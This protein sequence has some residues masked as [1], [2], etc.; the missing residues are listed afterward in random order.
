MTITAR[1]IHSR[2]SNHF[3]IQPPLSP[4]TTN[5]CPS[6]LYGEDSHWPVIG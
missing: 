6:A 2:V 4:Q 5:L 1:L 3:I